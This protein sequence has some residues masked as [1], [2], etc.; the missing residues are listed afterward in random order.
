MNIRDLRF[1][2]LFLEEQFGGDSE[3]L[4]DYNSD[5]IEFNGGFRIETKRGPDNLL[6]FTVVFL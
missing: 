5:T 1:L 6:E 4:F 3:V 2:V